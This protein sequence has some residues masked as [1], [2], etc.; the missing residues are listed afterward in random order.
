MR[1]RLRNSDVARHG[2]VVFAGVV[3]ASV[4]NY[5][6]YMLIGRRASI[7]TYGVVTSLASALLVL[8]APATVAQLIAAR[9]AADLEARA[10][11]AAL[12]KLAD[13]VTFWAAAA[14]AVI[15]TIGILFRDRLAAFFNLTSATPIVVA[16]IATGLLAVVIVQRGVFQGAHRFEAF[17]ASSSIDAT[18]KVF[19]GVPLVTAFGA[20]GALS[21]IVGGVVLALAFN[22]LAFRKSFGRVRAPV[23]LDRALVTRVVS[24]VGLGQF[25]FTVLMFYDVP[26]IKH[27]FDARSAGLY[28]AAA[29][30]GRAV[31]AAISFVPT[32]IM[33]KA[34]ARVAAGRSPLPLLAAALAIGLTI[35]G[36][37]AIAALIAPRFVVTL[38]AG[39]SFGEAAPLVLAYTIASG[40]L[41]LANV[42]AA[43]KM[44]LHEYHF[45]VPTALAGLAEVVVLAVW[46]PSLMTAVMILLCGHFAV[47]ATTLLRLRVPRSASIR[48]PGPVAASL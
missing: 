38:V 25:A 7:E 40:A 14:A 44:G 9:L 48:E 28:A 41:S 19:V 47:L 34:T 5:L 6:Y 29:L 39:R 36:G 11:V 27:A 10:D 30:V 43:Y 26:L 4:F 18:T 33:P 13:V 32:L 12:R 21:G 42:V 22:L 17:A 3:L 16:L 20:A 23:S 46:H 31:I 15:V 8:T 45:V 1:A 37:A 24:H 35:A 2:A